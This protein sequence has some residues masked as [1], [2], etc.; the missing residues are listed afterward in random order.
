MPANQVLG[1]GKLYF[2]KFNPY[3]VR[4]G[5]RYLGNSPELSINV[6]TTQLDHFNS[7]E[8]LK[9]KDDSVILQLD[10]KGSFS[11]DE[12]TADNQSLFVIGDKSVQS[13]SS[14]TAPTG[15]DTFI[16]AHLDRYYQ[17][18][19]TAGNPS[20]LRNVTTV[21]V[22]N[23]AGSPVTYALGTDYTVDLAQ[24][25]IYT[26][27]TGTIIDGT[28]NL[29]VTYGATAASR[30]RIVTSAV[31]SVDGA[32]RF[33]AFNPKGPNRD[34]FF[35]YVRLSPNGDF[36]LKGDDWQKI[37]FN[38]DILQLD[39]ATAHIYIDGRPYTP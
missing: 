4:T 27:P 32:L 10:R 6:S 13:Q 20:G 25:R 7:D 36:A 22:K 30:E 3:P 19:R 23:D 1:R 5:E 38:M 14:I 15:T 31:A 21:V 11:V 28:T 29:V 37:P 18:G 2:D 34:W 24:G 8:G 9:I 33:V 12:I 16:A 26:V 39:A 35:P 17:L